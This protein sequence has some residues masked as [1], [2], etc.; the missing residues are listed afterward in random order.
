MR[1]RVIERGNEGLDTDRIAAE[2]GNDQAAFARAARTMS[3]CASAKQDGSLGQ[4]RRGELVPAI[5]LA[6]EALGDGETGAEPVRSR[7]GWH[8]LRLQR[9]LPGRTIPFEMVSERIADMLEA[10]VRRRSDIEVVSDGRPILLQAEAAGLRPAH[11]CRRGICH[12]CAVPID[13]ALVRICVTAPD[14]DVELD[15]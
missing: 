3:G 10:H 8:V 7:F 13:G 14:G 5:Q 6:L 1:D 2:V 15:L 9:R 11:G 4:V 12:T